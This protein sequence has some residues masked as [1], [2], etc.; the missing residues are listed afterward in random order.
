MQEAGYVVVRQGHLMAVV[1]TFLMGCAGLVAVGCTGVRS[2][3]PQEEQGH[4]EVTNEQ[5]RLPEAMASESTSEEDR[6]GGTRT[7]DR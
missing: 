5:A 6:C 3:A 4:T 7:F 2:E 1:G